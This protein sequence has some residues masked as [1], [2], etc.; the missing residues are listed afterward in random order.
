MTHPS[1]AASGALSG[2]GFEVPEH[3]ADIASPL[4]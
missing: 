2:D 1:I 3:G 4:V